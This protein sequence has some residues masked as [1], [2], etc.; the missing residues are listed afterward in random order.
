[1][2]RRALL[3][4]L[5][6]LVASLTACRRATPAPA[7]GDLTLALKADV[8]GFF[9]NPP[10]VSETSTIDLNRSL[11][12]GLVELGP[13]LRLQPA[14]AQRWESPDERTFVFDLR[15]GL[16]FSDG[17]EVTAEDAAASLN[18]AR[19]RGWVTRDNLH[20]IESA[21]A[22]GPLRLEIRTR[23]PAP[24]LLSR[25]SQGFVLPAAAVAQ[26]P[27]P[28]VG[29]GPY[30]LLDWQPG[31]EFTFERNA[32]YRGRPPA[33]ARVRYVVVPDD[34]ERLAMVLDGRAQAADR[35]PAGELEHLEGR[36]DVRLVSRPSLRILFLALRPDR[37]PF[38]D[39]RVRE[40]IDLALDREQLVARALGGHGQPASQIVPTAVVGHDAEL[41]VTRPDRQRS[42]QLLAAAG[43][44]PGTELRLHGTNNR[45]VGDAQLLDEVAR[46]LGEVGLRVRVQAL[47]KARFFPLVE[48]GRSDFY[49]LGWLCE[50]GSA[51]DV[52]GSLLHSRQPGGLGAYNTLG[53]ADAELDRLTEAADATH[54]PNDRALL[55]KQALRRVHELRV[56][57]PL[58][59]PHNSFVISRRLDWEVP[60]LLSLRAEHLRPATGPGR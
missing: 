4:A 43:L 23:G 33:F 50:S 34:H 54:Q 9:P 19:Q 32:F 46:Q 53:L 29:T 22:L 37:A 57:L 47:D 8:T 28:A 7:P 42:R 27:V 15:P 45:Y 52:L 39:P 55:L 11:F 3:L 59:Q 41:R 31:R 17:R 20:D 58:V 60:E 51:S 40:A 10:I 18:A 49:L 44:R 56:T 5:A 21:R 38:S 16:R 2:A 1:M 25:L 14:L 12:E 36:T 26:E 30:R 13:A 35:V 48:A 24:A 6:V